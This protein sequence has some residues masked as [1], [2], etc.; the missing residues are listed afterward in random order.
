VYSIKDEILELIKK[1]ES[2]TVEWKKST[3]LL[4]EAIQ[5]ICAFAN[6]HG[7][8]VVFG[9]DDRGRILG[10]QVTDDTI[11]NIS[12]AMK[13]NTDPK[14]YPDI[15]KIELEGKTCLLVSV[16]ESPLK[17]HLAYGRAYFRVGTT[18][19]KLDRDHYEYLL[20]QRYNGYGF[21][22]Q[23]H[24]NAS[25]DDIDTDSLYE[26]LDTANSIRNL[27]ENML[28]PPD[29]ILKKMDLMNE[30]GITKAALLLFGK[31][32]ARFFINHFEVKCGRFLDDEGYDEIEND[33]EFSGNLIS[34][35][36]AVINFVLES[37]N[38]RSLKGDVHRKEEWELP[39]SVIREA[40]VN[41]IV[42]RDYRQ[43]IKSTLEI[44]PSAISFYNPGLLFGPSITIDRLKTLHPS[45]PGNKLIAKIFY[46][47]GLFENWGGGTLKIISETVKSGKPSPEFSFEGGMF[48]LVLFR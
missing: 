43:N 28:L 11:K 41:M 39:V 22:H 15:E 1:G 40:I 23:I 2:E 8:Y 37:I 33:K 13:L 34:I 27:N 38:K 35:F 24:G 30:K 14:L 21:D 3:S 19:Q 45:R 47:M 42:H 7:G 36:K 46:L 29:M 25:L 4:R 10:Q 5:T 18:N 16:D 32:P 20:Q 44:R 9:I 12:N 48:R 6:H 26:F 31:N 17:P